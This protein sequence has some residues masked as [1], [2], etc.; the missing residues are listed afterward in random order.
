MG[1]QPKHASS[2]TGGQPGMR[3]YLIQTLIALLE[4]LAAEPAFVRLTLEPNH[5]SEK[6]DLLWEDGTATRAVQVKS[7]VNAFA[8]PSVQ[9]WAAELEA[10]APATEYR[11]CLV[12][13]TSP[14]VANLKQVGKVT[15]EAK[16]LDL[17]AFREQA[18]HRLDRFLRTEGLDTGT[19]EQREMLADALTARL[20]TYSTS[21]RPLARTD[22][23]KLLKT[24]VAEAPTQVPRISPTRLRHGAQK[25]FGR[26][27]DLSA[28]DDAWADPGTHILSFV[29]W[30]GVGKTSLVVEWM[31]RRAK[32]GWPGIRRVFAWSFYSQGSSDHSAASADPFV[33]KALEFFGDS[34]MAQSGALPWDKGARLAQLIVQEPTLL[35]LDGLEPLQY[36]P[37]TMGG[38]LKDPTL[39]VLLKGLAQQ[40]P[41][42][43]V[44]TTREG[45]A[46]LVPFQ[47]ST[48]PERQ[49]LHL[50]AEAGV[51]LLKTLGVK[52][53]EKE[54]VELVKKIDGH[55]LTLDLLGR[56]LA[57]AHGG[58]VRRSD[59]LRFE[60]A[61]ARV[62]GGH[63]FRAIG[64]YEKWLGESGEDGRRQLAVL[65]LMGLFD[66]PA[67][68]GCLKALRQE[69]VIAGLTDP[70]V[71]LDEEDWNLTLFELGECGLVSAQ[72]ES[73]SAAGGEAGGLDAHP[74]VREYFGKQLREKSPEAW[75]LAHQRLYEYLTSRTEDQPDTLAGLQPLYQAVAHGCLAGL[76]QKACD[77]VYHRRILR[78]DEGYSWR[79]LGAFG[80]ELGAVSCFFEQPWR[81]VSPAL[82]EGGQAWLLNEA[83]CR[84]RALGRLNEALE[85][86]RAGLE[87]Y[88]QQEDWKN[89][90]AVA[91]NLSELELTL[92]EVSEAEQDA[93]RS[94]QF[95]DRSGDAI[96]RMI[97]RTTLA[98]AQHQA[99]R[100]TEALEL[101]SQAESLQEQVQP[102]YPVLYSL[103][104]YQYCD[105]LLREAERTAWQE[106][107]KSVVRGQKLEY[108]HRSRN[109]ERRAAWAMEIV[110][111]GSRNLLDIALTHLMLGRA[112]LYRTVLDRSAFRD[113]Q[114]A[115]EPA[116]QE[117]AAAVDGLRQ[118]GDQQYVPRGLL[119]RAWLRFLSGDRAGTAADLDEAWEIAERGP[120]RLHMADVHLHR[121]RLFRDKTAL[122]E[123]RKLIERCGY[124]RRKEELEDAEQAAAKW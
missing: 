110:L 23:V 108:I 36:P 57:R 85:S 17:P 3:G 109:V 76:Q 104:G 112:A 88:V 35:V 94:V 1:L 84:L 11:L 102:Q 16:N 82:S 63:A 61:D 32:A 48:A 71:G 120:M 29:A 20:A 21:G 100:Q 37:G 124:W 54:L 78:A 14:A 28:I 41:G 64:A 103:R 70:L 107:R 123:A 65:R 67:E 59:Q 75:R 121:A 19:A 79:K 116:R 115:L 98:D 7:S 99:G 38:Q 96:E 13:L 51:E 9:R 10:S 2:A 62:Q 6:F 49:L 97:N 39:A 53:S 73:S 93:D 91:G 74:L 80:A 72:G 24:W 5:A 34:E 30:A 101:F 68:A 40:N 4:G 69:P 117:L 33:A 87:N 58:D 26:E 122:A 89:A 55:A 118:A 8:K 111:N 42:L 18:A 46:D 25:L 56:F 44:L 95:A 22:L 47:N 113:P 83:A 12:G 50:S 60:K 15:L 105:L 27:K 119:S 106:M 90:A 52:G 77:E 43:C 31:A 66:R 92:G 81:Q 45:V 86:M 114:A